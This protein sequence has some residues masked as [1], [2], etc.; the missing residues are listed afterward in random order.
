MSETNANTLCERDLK[1]IVVAVTIVVLAVVFLIFWDRQQKRAFELEKLE[2]RMNVLEE[3]PP[4]NNVQQNRML[5]AGGD[6]VL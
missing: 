1:K 4:T 6:K 3:W 2:N 5:P